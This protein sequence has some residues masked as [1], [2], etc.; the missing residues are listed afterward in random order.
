MHAWR[1]AVLCAAAFATAAP[2]LANDSSAELATGGLVFVKNP[3][4]T[5]RS[6]RLLISAAEIR[7]RY[8]F[9]NES[10]ADVANTVAFPMPD[11]TI[12]EPDENLAIPTENP[13]NIL[14]FSTI[15]DG[16]P[17]AAEV[18]QK[19]FAQ[20]LDR[21]ELL[22]QL[23]LPLAP[24]LQTT[25]AALDRLP[26]AEWPRLINLGLAEIEKYDIGTGMKEH[27]VPRWTLKT[28]YFW[29]QIF[30]ARREIVIEHR[31][32][33]SVGGSVGTSLGEPGFDGLAAL[34]R[35]YC[36][37]DD[38]LRAVV[39]ARQ[40]AHSTYGAPFAEHRIDYILSTGANWAGPIGDFTLIVDK[41]APGNLVSFCAEGVK[42][43]APTRFE[44]HKTDFVPRSDLSV[45]ILTPQPR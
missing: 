41:G 23:G 17:V 39:R 21:T 33:P 20:G 19:V 12:S 35:K 43:T 6:E 22:R 13:E 2:A 1:T 28:T 14:N 31:Y 5:M 4:V 9:F 15:A 8:A 10:E 18:E 11:I 16:R 40:A 27:L 42:K 24:Q 37:D 36:I 38:F 44:V 3:A 32:K 26:P 29:Q 45:L 34:R 30:P 7:V 25:A